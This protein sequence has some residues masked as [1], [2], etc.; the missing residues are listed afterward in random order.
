MPSHPVVPD[1][2][3][4]LPTETAEQLQAAVG[5]DSPPETFHDW[6]AEMYASLAAGPALARGDLYLDE[7]SRHAVHLGDRVEHV[8]CVQDGLI[9]AVLSDRDPVTVRSTSPA[10]GTVVEV[11]VAAGSVEVTP[12]GAVMSFGLSTDL[13]PLGDPDEPPIAWVGQPAS[14]LRAL[15]CDYINAFPTSEALERWTDDLERVAIVELTFEQGVA[16]AQAAANLLFEPAAGS[17]R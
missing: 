12:P 15:S 10:D 2:G 14:P 8:P 3:I 6:A 11:T 1:L 9:V 4:D 16:L 17:T 5:L 7:A 13:P